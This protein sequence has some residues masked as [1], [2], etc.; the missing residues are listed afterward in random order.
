M[1]ATSLIF[2]IAAVFCIA[3]CKKGGVAPSGITGKW[4]L[5]R[6]YGGFAYHDS[7]YPAG[8]G[9]MYQFNSNGTYSSFTQGQLTAHGKFV[10][11]K[12]GIQW[13]G[14]TFD[15]ILFDGNTDGQLVTL[16]DT[17]LTFGTTITDGIATDYVKIR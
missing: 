3:S 14:T 6:S 16:K 5:R 10:F 15:E 12:D 11:K 9:N 7:V 2:L 17:V 4:E 8:S 1:K 13:S